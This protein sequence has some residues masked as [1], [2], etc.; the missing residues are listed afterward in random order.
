MSKTTLNFFGEVAIIDTPKDM[1]SLRAKI[2][3]KYLLSSSDAAE[4]II[5][6][7]KN[8][9]KAYII[10]GNDLSQFKESDSS[11]IFLD[12]NQNSKLYLD[13]ASELDK[14]NQKNQKELDEINHKYK[15]F[16]K[17][18][19]KVEHVFEDEL[20][21]INLKIMELNKQKC[22][23]IK[24]K[25]IELIKMIKEK[26]HYENRI[27]YLQK[28]LF[29]PITVPIPK[30]EKS[31]EKRELPMLKSFKNNER[32]A[33][34]KDAEIK[35]R[36]EVA[37]CRAIESA[38]AVILKGM[39][40][41]GEKNKEM[42]KRIETIKLK[43]VES[44]KANAL[45]V[46][47]REH[48]AII[49][50]KLEIEKRIK[51]AKLNSIAAAE[52]NAIKIG[53]RAAHDAIINNKLEIG[54]RIKSA[55]LNSVAA[56][57][58]NSIK[59]GKRAAHEAIINNKLEIEKIIK[60]AKLS[61]I[62]AAEAKAIKI[63]KRAAHEAMINN[64]GKIQMNIE[65][66]KSKTLPKVKAH[67]LKVAKRAH[68]EIINKKGEIK[69]RIDL[70]K[71]KSIASA[72]SKALKLGKLAEEANKKIIPINT[73]PVFNKVKEVLNNTVDKVKEIAKAVIM[74]QNEEPK[75]EEI[76]DEKERL[77]KEEEQKKLKEKEKKEQID[78]II[79]I[80]KETVNEIN[81]LTKMVIIQS[82]NLIEQINNQDKN[83]MM[84]HEDIIL[85]AGK[86]E[87]K[88]K[89]AI[90][91]HV[92]CDGCKMNPLRGNR[93]KCKGCPDFDF[94]ESCYQKN[95]ESHAHAHEFKLI[96]KPKNTRRMGFKNIKYCQR[97][98]VH[99]D[100]RCE[101][102]GLFRLV[103][104]R[105]MCTIC[106][107]FSLCENCEET[108]AV[109]H[110]HPFIKVTYPSLINSF[111]NCYLKMNYYEPKKFNK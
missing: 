65:L 51:S 110:G 21:Q 84:S 56:A 45:K 106:D 30:D 46:A 103:G 75:K 2:S 15:E 44:A 8:S 98:I 35:K 28:K 94:C 67:A 111:N 22:E 79:K 43:A 85:K 3:E 109:M 82:N 60:N 49:N 25:D 39:K 77:K 81:S 12:I 64:K 41:E 32:Y 63:G 61:S 37:K 99:K 52:A 55:K 20:K 6:Y 100:V 14:E 9:K 38:K 54:K 57:E 66:V 96:E 62:A 40:K 18:K 68:E 7:I 53:K 92:Q 36:I 86:K 70:V 76:K 4:L 26:E 80:A 102:C 1:P 59:I 42:K 73:V 83:V 16:S 31:N 17:R 107:D 48:D 23:I 89:D 69:K 93:Y 108:N 33:P 47:K 91:F 90:H 10:N 88:E 95:N 11:T 72:E 87:K 71:S 101:H 27:Y 50:N 34:I 105:Y 5:Y 24:K 74:K 13:S 29:L 78:K 104:Y 97:G 19:E 58:A